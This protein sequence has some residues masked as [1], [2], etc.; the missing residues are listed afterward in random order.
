[1]YTLGGFRYF[2]SIGLPIL[3]VFP[4]EDGVI[5]KCIYDPKT[6]KV[7]FK[8]PEKEV[9]YAYIT[10]TEHPLNDLHPLGKIE[11]GESIIDLID[12]KYDLLYV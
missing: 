12:T 8:E 4:L 7:D 11:K 2:A 6:L 10:I 1:M 9:T 5:V 3:N